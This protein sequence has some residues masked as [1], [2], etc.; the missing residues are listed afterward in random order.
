MIAAGDAMKTGIMACLIAS[1]GLFLTMGIV[2]KFYGLGNFR[3]GIDTRYDAASL[4]QKI[5]AEPGKAALVVFPLVFPLDL[6][7]L[8][9]FAAFVALCS[10]L[11]AAG[12]GIPS[13]AIWALLVLPIGYLVSDFGENALFCGMLAAP[14]RITPAWVEVTQAFTYVKLACALAASVQ[15]CILMYFYWFPRR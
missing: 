7:F 4:Q 2:Q 12:A 15:A 13:S 8:T 14:Q 6:L 9:F 10:L 3:F 11:G 5:R 1:L